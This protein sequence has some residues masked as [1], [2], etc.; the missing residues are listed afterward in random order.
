MKGRFID[1][2][3]MMQWVKDDQAGSVLFL[4]DVDLTLV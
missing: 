1:D 2:C 4:L 3:L